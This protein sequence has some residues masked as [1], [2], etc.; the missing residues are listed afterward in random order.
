MR[1]RYTVV[2]VDSDGTSLSVL[3]ET[4]NLWQILSDMEFDGKTLGRRVLKVF[5]GWCEQAEWS[6][7]KKGA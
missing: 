3:I 2:T 6:L 7:K 4:D 5:R 1:Q